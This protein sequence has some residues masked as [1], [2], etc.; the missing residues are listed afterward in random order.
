MCRVLFGF[1]LGWTFLIGR[2]PLS[3]STQKTEFKCHEVTWR[4]DLPGPTS[5]AFARARAMEKELAKRYN[6]TFVDT[7]AAFSAM[8]P[9]G[10]TPPAP[11]NAVQLDPIKP[12]LQAPGTKRLKLKYDELLSNVAFKFKLRR[13]TL[14]SPPPPPGTPP[15]PSSTRRRASAT[16][17]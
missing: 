1:G 17:R 6:L 7:C 5:G 13:Y 10:G 8:L 4:V 3:G 12:M 16:P 15:P 9:R 14:V 11:G 2:M